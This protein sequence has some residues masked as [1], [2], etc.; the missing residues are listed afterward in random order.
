[1]LAAIH[2]LTVL[3]TSGLH[4]SGEGESRVALNGVSAGIADG[5]IVGIV[6]ESG[7][8]KSTLGLALAGMLPGNAH[9]QQGEIAWSRP[10]RAALI[11]QSVSPTFSPYLR[12]GA[13]VCDVL[14][15]HGCTR[16]DAATR[17]VALLEEAGLPPARQAFDA[18][19]HELSGG[20]LQRVAIARA[21]AMAPALLVADEC[22]ASLDLLAANT[23]RST[24]RALNERH[25]LSI[26]WI[27]H[28]LSE[29]PGFANRVLTLH[30][31]HCVDSFAANPF[32]G[33]PLHPATARLLAA[34]PRPVFTAGA[35]ES[36]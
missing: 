9:V 10:A 26:L 5:E 12:C 3:Y 16:R 36:K 34:V 27:T 23:L 29:L 17:A 35:E 14:L 4:T 31:G 18:W 19:P 6:G 24:L 22:A 20:E 2:N 32:R 21:L 15:A 11:P 25:K 28:D 7:S 30:D 8:G 1:M 33:G 13:Q